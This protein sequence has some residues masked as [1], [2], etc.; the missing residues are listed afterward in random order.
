VAVLVGG[1][2]CHGV[3]EVVTLTPDTFVRVAARDSGLFRAGFQ[4]LKTRFIPQEDTVCTCECARLCRDTGRTGEGATS[5]WAV[6]QDA[7]TFPHS[8][9]AKRRSQALAL[10]VERLAGAHAIQTRGDHVH[11]TIMA[12]RCRCHLPAMPREHVTDPPLEFG[13]AEAGCGGGVRSGS[14]AGAAQAEQVKEV[15]SS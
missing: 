13:G 5:P 11:T 12:L 7:V 2:D 1:Q 9:H 15:L 3:K 6:S 14:G 4:F 8:S 10:H